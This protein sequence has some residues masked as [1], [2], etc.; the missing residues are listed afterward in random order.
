MKLR[1]RRQE[2][3][4]G[5]WSVLDRVRGYRICRY[6]HPHHG[7]THVHHPETSVPLATVDVE[8]AHEAEAVMRRYDDT[9]D[10]FELTK[11]QE[12][13]KTWKSESAAG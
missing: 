13:I 10:A 9:H 7:G 8:A 3:S 4:R 11:L 12:V 2:S 6:N 1:L 5:E